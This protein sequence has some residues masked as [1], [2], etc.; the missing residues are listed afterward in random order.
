MNPIAET[1]LI[2]LREL[3][4][5]FKSVKGI[6]LVVLSLLGGTSIT[7]LLVK[8][9]QFEIE[10]FG[11]DVTPEQIH[12][13]REQIITKTYGDPAMGHY[14]ADAP[15]VLLGMLKLSVWFAP[16]L[17]VLM[18]FDGIA[19][20]VQHRSVRYWT[21]RSRRSSYFV[22]K[23][24]GLWMTVSAIT[25]AMH[26][27]VW[28]MCIARGGATPAVTISWG[29]RFWLVSLPIS[30]AWCGIATLVGSLFR[31]PILALLV[32]L[33]TFFVIWLLFV[34]G[35]VSKMTALVYIYP[36][37]YDAWLLSPRLDRVA[38]GLGVCIGIAAATIGGG[39]LLFARRDV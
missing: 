1:W 17:I 22:G 30:A 13:V 3:R 4:K 29:A 7:L 15:E 6:V 34:I 35:D 36:N 28:I 31:T 37:Y 27:L 12:Q 10:T 20:D 23:F 14:L 24:V 39:S 11:K 26:L 16:L 33:G 18:G 38:S 25:L 8:F 19:S 2:V 5:N 21:V 32:T 9:Q